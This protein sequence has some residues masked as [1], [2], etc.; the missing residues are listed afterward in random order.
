MKS[1]A[2]N[3]EVMAEIQQGEA[4]DMGYSGVSKYGYSVLGIYIE[5]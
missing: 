5:S 2:F 1:L 3:L 4:P